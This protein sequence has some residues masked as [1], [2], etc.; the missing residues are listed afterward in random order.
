MKKL[1]LPLLLAAT[2][3]AAAQAG[4]YDPA[5]QPVLPIQYFKPAEP[6]LFVGDCMPF[7]YRGTFYLYWLLDEGHHAGLGG[8]GGHQWALS[9]S[10]DLVHWTHRPVALGIDEPW[11]KS[12]CT[13]SVIDADSAIYAFYSTRV[14]DADGVREQLSYAVSRD[15]GLRFEKRRP[16]PFFLTPARYD[17]RNFR[18]PKIFRGDD[19][20]YHLFISSDEKRIPLTG[21]GGCLVHLVSDDLVSWHE[22]DPVLT[23]QT[24]VPECSDYFAWNG[25]YY[26]L[27]SVGGD[28]Y[29]VR[30]AQPFGPWEYPSSQAFAEGW[31]NVYKT[32]RFRDGRRIGAAFIPWR[33][34]AR[35]NGGRCFGG[36]VL[37]REV[38]QGCDGM[39]YT[40]FVEEALPPAAL[41]D[42][43]SLFRTWDDR[44]PLSRN[45]A[46]TLAS[47]DGTASAYLTDL[48][49]GY[50]LSMR[51]EP[52]SSYDEIGLF[53]RASDSRDRG[54]K[55]EMNAVKRMVLLHNLRI[56]G[57]AGLERP[58]TLDLIVCGDLIDVC[59]DGRRCAINRLPEAKGN[60]VFFFV[61]NG[62]ARFRDLRIKSLD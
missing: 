50:R 18:D 12:I 48:P 3:F 30:S 22:V 54:Y 41:Y 42:G 55:L 19:G 16:N 51:V 23:G 32:A 21:F 39:L 44:T 4:D 38:F 7:D 33:G 17:A 49:L 11:E 6:H 25:W 26:L 43:W 14:E 2:P 61:K 47:A 62:T 8:L 31:A 1:L 10:E 40:R 35:D 24:G 52:C 45:G 27:Y 20:R 9:T 28:T 13:G 46:F 34:E 58:F 60:D 5:I 59:I 15:G 53:V 36:N 56:E 57:V 29:Y 37:L